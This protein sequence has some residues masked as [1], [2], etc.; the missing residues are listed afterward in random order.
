MNRRGSAGSL[1]L[2]EFQYLFLTKIDHDFPFGRHQTDVLEVLYLIQHVDVCV[3]MRTEEIV[4]SDPQ[5][6][7]IVGTDNAVEAVC[8]PV[9]SFISPVEPLNQLLHR[10]EFRGDGVGVGKTDHLRDLELHPV[11]EFTEE[12]LGSKRI[13]TVAVGDEPEPFREMIIQL[14]ESLAHCLDAGPD[15]A[16]HRGCI[17]DDGTADSVHDEPDVRLHPTDFDVSLICD[18]DVARMVIVMVNERFHAEGCCFAVV[19]D[20]LT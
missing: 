3:S 12:L 13:G 2:L 4:V 7:V 6:K 10:T 19:R 8:C 17:A 11:T 16:V 18:K 14:P 20:L 5:S 9:R 15:R 1:L